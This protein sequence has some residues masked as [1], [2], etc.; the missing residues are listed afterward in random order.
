M[1]TPCPST[2]TPPF[3]HL[4]TYMLILLETCACITLMVPLYMG[5]PRHTQALSHCITSSI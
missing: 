4:S 2:E 3:R 5:Q 1:G